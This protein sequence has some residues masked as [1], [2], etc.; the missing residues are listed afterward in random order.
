MGLVATIVLNAMQIYWF[1]CI[2]YIFMSWLPNAR[3]SAFGQGVGRLVEPFFE[4]F[5]R[6]I[7]PIGMIDISPIVALF[8]LRFAMDGV[9]YLFSFFM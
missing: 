1:I 6:I 8:A 7:P 2:I 4:P 5:R 9:R 3:E